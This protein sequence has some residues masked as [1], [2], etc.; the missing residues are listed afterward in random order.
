MHYYVFFSIYGYHR[1]LYV[2]TH[3]FP[4][5]RSSDLA[6]TRLLRVQLDDQRLVDVRQDLVARRH[7]LECSLQT[8][9]VDVNPVGET[10]LR[11]DRQRFD[12]TRLATRGFADF[13]PVA[14]LDLVRRDIDEIAID[15]VRLVRNHL[16]CFFPGCREYGKTRGEEQ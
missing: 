5:R 11:G 10:G 7:G 15:S 2:L 13:N 3:S 4:T 9:F 12:D 6:R 8:L 16:T 1:D 14:R